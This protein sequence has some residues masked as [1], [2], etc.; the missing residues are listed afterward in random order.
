LWLFSSVLI[1]FL[2]NIWGVTIQNDN[3][4][5]DTHTQTELMHSTPQHFL[6]RQQGKHGCQQHGVSQRV[7]L[8]QPQQLLCSPQTIVIIL[9]CLPLVV[10][11][12]ELHT[13]CT[14]LHLVHIQLYLIQFQLNKLCL[15]MEISMPAYHQV[16]QFCTLSIV[17]FFIYN[18]TFRRLDSVS[19]F[20]WNPVCL[21]LYLLDPTV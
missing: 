21:P 3:D 13:K 5:R 6:I 2:N 4:E 16:L 17:L 15:R 11:I 14:I 8:R 9:I 10:S 1:F 19:V 18:S 7:Y 12:K 20:R